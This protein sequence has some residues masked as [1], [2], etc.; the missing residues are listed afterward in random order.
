LELVARQITEVRPLLEEFDRS[1]HQLEK[2]EIEACLTTLA[3]IFRVQP[4]N[5]AALEMQKECQ[6]LLEERGR[7]QERQLRL[8]SALSLAREAFDRGSPAQCLQAASRALQIEP[9]NVQALELQRLAVE[10]LEQRRRVEELVAAARVYAQ[11]GEYESS[12]RVASEGL[13]LDAGNEELRK[14]Q[15]EAQEA[16]AK[17]DKLQKLVEEARRQWQGKDYPAVLLAVGELLRLEPGQGEA[18]ELSQQARELL[19]REGKMQ[20]LLAAARAQA[21]A[22]E[23]ESSYRVATEGLNLDAG[24]DELRKLQVEAQQ[25]LA[26][27]RR[28]QELVERARQQQGRE[29]YAGVLQAVEELLKVEPGHGE[30]LELRRQAEEALERRRK[31]EEVLATARAHAL[32]Q[33]YESCMRVSIEGLSLEPENE[34]LK[35]LQI[36]AQQALAKRQKVQELVERARQQRKQEDSG[37]VLHTAEELLRQEPEEAEASEM[38][39]V[40]S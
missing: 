34:D 39:R 22:G 38:K 5:S 17:R 18:L 31:V 4:K 21:Q 32:A 36:Q 8:E 37:A 10:A 11:A 7:T 25:A 16:L 14:L 15:T 6:R 28:V 30:A 27:R 12:H 9:G 3:E 20:A 2:N 24:N 35:R 13:N 23:Y 1:R 26:K 29:E 19:E 40:A 33:E